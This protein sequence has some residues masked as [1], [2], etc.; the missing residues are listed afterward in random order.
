MKVMFTIVYIQYTIG[1]QLYLLKRYI[2]K[3]LKVA[4][5][6]SKGV[7]S[8]KFDALL[9]ILFNTTCFLI[10]LYCCCCCRGF[11]IGNHFCEW[12][13]DYSNASWPGYFYNI[14]AYPTVQQQVRQRIMHAFIQ[15]KLL[16]PISILYFVPRLSLPHE[17]TPSRSETNTDTILF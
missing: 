12:M 6:M 5:K 17:L 9:L 16:L 15:C 7:C 8:W 1:L 3:E 10:L 11:D 13:Y 2:D 4:F 14:D